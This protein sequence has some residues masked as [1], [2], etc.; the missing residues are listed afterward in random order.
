MLPLQVRVKVSVPA[1]VGVTVMVP[2]AGCEP[3]HAP[4]AVQLVPAVAIH[5][6]VVERPAITELGLT[7]IDTEV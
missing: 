1:L 3:L 4:L 2:P 5:V 7:L 6:R